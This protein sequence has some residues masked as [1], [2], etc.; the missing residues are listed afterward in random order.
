MTLSTF[1]R[2]HPVLILALSGLL[3]APLFAQ[4]DLPALS[5]SQLNRPAS[6]QLAGA[7]ATKPDGSLKIVPTDRVTGSGVL[8]GGRDPLTLTTPTDDFRMRFDLLMTTGTDASVSLPTGQTLSF[9]QDRDLARLLKAPGLWQTLELWYRTGRGNSP[10]MLEK[11]TLNGVMVREGQLLTGKASGPVALMAPSGTVAVRNVG[12]RVLSA[13]NV[14]Q[15]SGPLSYTIYEGETSKRD[16]L[17]GKTVLKQDTTAMVNYEVAY[18]QPRRYSI[19]F[20]GK[21]NALQAGDYQFDLHQGG[22][23]G[24][25]IDG[26]EIIPATYHDLSQ[27]ETRPAALTAGPHE[28]QVFFTRSWARPGLGLYVSQAGT[29]PQPLHTLASLPEPDPVGVI[30]VTPETKSQLIRSFVQMPGEK[31]KRTHSLSVGSPGG[32]HYTLDL[33]Q[34]ALLQAWKGN[35]AN[36]TEMWHERGEPQLLSPLGTTVYLPA[37]PAL[38]VLTNDNTPWPDSISENSLHYKELTVDKQGAPTITYE[39]AGLT[40]TDAIRTRQNGLETDGLV[41]T[42]SLTG[43]PDGTPFCRVAAGSSIEEVSK[44]LY[45]INDRSYYI[46]F[47]PKANVK[48]RQSSGKQ[49]L[50]LPVPMKNGVGLVAYAIIF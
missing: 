49:E 24:L 2:S 23:A 18:G 48:L 28:I 20:T 4:S 22:I 9:R 6:W 37:Q 32:Y 45:A 36:V 5:L 27:P 35:F 25:W 31:T 13:R 12:Y 8:V 29:R 46:Q 43:S 3:S 19:L 15:W 40:V 21:L 50:L 7:I 39:L 38:L 42:L 34:M 16:E 47:D 11:L 44:G 1:S 10:A 26:K 14:A 17:A 33:N 41:R 30:S